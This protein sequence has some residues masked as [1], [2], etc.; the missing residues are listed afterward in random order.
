MLS[1]RNLQTGEVFCLG[2]KRYFRTWWQVYAL[3]GRKHGLTS[4][5]LSIH[6]RKQTDPKFEKGDPVETETAVF[7]L[8]PS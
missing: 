7:V 8:F 2:P 5:D 1:L 4:E 6:P 3:L